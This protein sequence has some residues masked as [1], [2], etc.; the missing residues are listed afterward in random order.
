MRGSERQ[1]PFFEQIDSQKFQLF[2]A[3]DGR[4]P[5]EIQ[6]F[7]V[8]KFVENHGRTP[9]PGEIGCTLSH[10]QLISDFANS[11]SSDEDY[12]VIA[13]DDIKFTP[14]FSKVLDWVC[15][16]KRTF[17]L[18]MLTDIFGFHH[19]KGIINFSAYGSHLSLL[20]RR[21]RI[22]GHSFRRGRFLGNPWST[23][24][25]MVSKAGAKKYVDLIERSNGKCWWEADVYD[26]WGPLAGIKLHIVKPSVVEFN[27]FDERINEDLYTRFMRDKPELVSKNPVNILKFIKLK[28]IMVLKATKIDILERLSEIKA[29]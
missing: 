14:Y 18:V 5:E 15:S 24:L 27:D 7:D 16:Q 8:P 28:S 4:N 20:S 10:A 11:D 2:N 26:I 25:Y 22:I 29:K 6:K 9:T 21:K 13:E 1:K 17:D 19:H 23:A 12:L 3:V